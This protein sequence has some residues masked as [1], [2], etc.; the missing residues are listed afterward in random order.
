MHSLKHFR[1]TMARQPSTY[2]LSNL[3]YLIVTVL[4]S[5]YLFLAKKFKCLG[6]PTF[7]SEC[8]E[9]SVPSTQAVHQKVDLLE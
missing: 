7:H 1:G 2:I 3:N 6:V 8:T 4:P 9:V 5:V